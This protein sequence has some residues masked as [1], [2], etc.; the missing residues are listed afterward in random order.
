MADVAERAN[1]HLKGRA[2]PALPQFT[3]PDSGITVGLR[4]FSPDT[5]DRIARELSR[6]SPPPPA[7]EIETELGAESNPADPDY[8]QALNAY[9]M[10]IQLETNERMFALALRQIEVDIDRAVLDRLKADME[11]I[12]TPLDA[13][14]DDRELYIRHVCISSVY[15]L[16][17]LLSYLQRRSLPTEEA[18]Q[19]HLDSFRGDVQ[20]KT[21]I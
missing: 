15:D 19:E 17:A 9:W 13:D 12:G 18:V 8:Q 20:A 11:E 1:G 6:K 14:K 16:T 7:P 21:D 2:A 3:F 10:R 4:R 5:Q